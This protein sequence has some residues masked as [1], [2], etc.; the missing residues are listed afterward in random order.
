MARRKL[1]KETPAGTLR[2]FV[3]RVDE[4]FRRDLVR[5]GTLYCSFE[6]P[7][8]STVPPEDHLV[9][10][11]ALFRQF[12]LQNEPIHVNAVKDAYRKVVSAPDLLEMLSLV[13]QT[14]PFDHGMTIEIEGESFL[15]K[16]WTDSFISRYFHSDVPTPHLENLDN[17][18][19]HLLLPLWL[20]IRRGLIIL[21]AYRYLIREA[22][23]RGLIPT[24]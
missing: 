2:L 3:Q 18:R 21:A 12:F 13:E 22:D 7:L 4:L 5:S 6:N 8:A 10:F 14:S 19:S 24:L 20:T 16:D 9:G 15:P 23:R 1:R 11:L 17:T